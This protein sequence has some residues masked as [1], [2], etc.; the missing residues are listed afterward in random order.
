MGNEVL[1]ENVLISAKLTFIEILINYSTKQT[2]KILIICYVVPDLVCIVFLS[3]LKDAKLYGLYTNVLKTAQVYPLFSRSFQMSMGF[4]MLI[5]V[6]ITI[7]KTCWHF[8][9]N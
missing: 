4:I 2:V 8:N 7:A 3:H 1:C 5:N 9:V 6:K